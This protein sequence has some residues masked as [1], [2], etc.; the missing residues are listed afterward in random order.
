MALCILPQGRNCFTVN[1]E[2]WRVVSM[3]CGEYEV[4]S[5]GNIR[6]HKTKE[7]IKLTISKIGYPVFSVPGDLLIPPRE[8]KRRFPVYAHVCVALAFIPNPRGC[9]EVNHID[10]NKANNNV[11]NL[12]WCTHA[13]NMKHAGKS[14]LCKGYNHKAIVQIKDGKIIAEYKSIEEAAKKTGINPTSIGCVTRNYVNKSGAHY[15]TAGGY[16]WKTKEQVT[17]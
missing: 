15:Y 6:K 12:E 8:R 7:P 13:E 3:L 9:K 1:N 4:S 10:G 2:E 5:C 11:N 16:Q 17:S 14:G